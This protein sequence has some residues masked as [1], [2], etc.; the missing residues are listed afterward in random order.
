MEGPSSRPM[1]GQFSQDA[2]IEDTD[3][4]VT[5]SEEEEVSHE[6]SST[7]S[8]SALPHPAWARHWYSPAECAKM[9]K[10]KGIAKSIRCPLIA[11][12]RTGGLL[13]KKNDP[14]VSGKVCGEKMCA[15]L[16]YRHHMSGFHHISLSKMTT[17]RRAICAIP[18]CS[19]PAAEAR[20]KR[21]GQQPG[22]SE[23]SYLR[24]IGG[25]KLRHCSLR[26]TCP[27][28]GC[29][30]SDPATSSFPRYDKLQKH[31][32]I[33][34]SKEE[35]VELSKYYKETGGLEYHYAYFG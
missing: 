8:T 33:E 7:S 13:R 28:K 32:T 6:S 4:D 16:D 3:R 19:S 23:S 5:T 20:K 30:K 25:E 18:G 14:A 24:H 26:W 22:M 34:H 1:G 12:S 2:D 11:T 27:V 17:D 35:M 10:D 29:P 9:R 31:I 21:S 15:G